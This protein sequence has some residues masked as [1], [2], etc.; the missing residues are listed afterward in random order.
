M[1][2]LP[3]RRRIDHLRHFFNAY[4]DTDA[5]A[6]GL[7]IVRKGEYEELKTEY[8]SL[9]LPQGWSIRLTEAESMGGKIRETQNEWWTKEWVGLLCDDLS[10]ETM[11]W[12]RALIARINGWNVVSCNDGWQAPK[13]MN[14]AV[15]WSGDLFR[16]VGYI[17]PDGLEHM[18]IDD[19]W[20]GLGKE[21]SCWYCD[22]GVTVRH[23][24]AFLTGQKDDT[25]DKVASFWDGD[26]ARYQT[27]VNA[28]KNTALARIDALQRS[29]EVII[30]KPD[31]NGVKLMIA[32]PTIDG[33]YHDEYVTSLLNTIKT[34][35]DLNVQ[36]EWAK[37]KHNADIALGRQKIL[38]AFM[39][40]N[41]THLLMIDSD[42]GWEP[43][44]VLRL[45]ST[46]LDLVGVAGPKKKYPLEFAANRRDDNNDPLPL[47]FNRETC[48]CEVD[49]LGMAFTL[50][51]RAC[52]QKMC[53]GYKHLIYKAIVGEGWE[54]GVYMPMLWK[55]RYLSEDYAFCQRWRDI[56]GVVHLCPDVALTHTGGHTFKGALSDTFKP[57]ETELKAAE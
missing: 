6:P 47:D 33:S 44:A 1:F 16:A 36:V 34:L 37:E 29:K 21:G 18:F 8:D 52:A 7:V 10:P 39:K 46:K 43:T 48:T 40:S 50:M 11:G 22:M 27:W 23:R 53:E 28:E 45:F 25:F 4:R 12:D 24:H 54:Y 14:G 2:L 9:K 5:T 56:G 51:T 15:L 3:T 13:R 35:S 55:G 49:H 38:A 42:M 30:L 17:Y 41:C 26:A 32:T 20:E 57:V 31:L 19:I